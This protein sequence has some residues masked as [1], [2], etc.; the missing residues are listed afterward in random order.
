LFFIIGKRIGTRLHKLTNGLVALP[1]GVRNHRLNAF[2]LDEISGAMSAYNKAMEHLQIEE[3]RKT[4]IIQESI[5]AKTQAEAATAAKADFLANMSH[6]IRTPMN[7]I[8]G[9]T[10]LLLDT[11]LDSEQQEL[12]RMIRTSAESLLH[13]INDI[14]DFSKLEFAKMKLESLPVNLEQ[15]FQETVGIFA[16]QASGKGVELNHHVDPAMPR[17]IPGDSLRIKQILVNL[18]GNAMKFTQDGEILLMAQSIVR[19]TPAGEMPYMH[20]SVRD[21]GIGIP[22]DK[23]RQLFQAFTQADNSTTRKYGGTGLG[24]AISSKLCHLMGGEIGVRSEDGRGSNFFF[25][26]P[27]KALPDDP[28][29]MEEERNWQAAVRSLTAS[30]ISSHPTT[31]QII[32]QHCAQSGLRSEVSM[33]EPGSTAEQFLKSAPSLIVLDAQPDLAPLMMETVTLARSRGIAVVGATP[34]G[35]DPFKQAL[36]KA[37]GARCRFINKPVSR[38]DLMRAV[39]V[40]LSEIERNQPVPASIPVA[41]PAAIE[42]TAPPMVQS[43]QPI[44][45]SMETSTSDQAATETDPKEIPHLFADDFPAR[46]LVVEDQPMNQ[47]LARMMLGKLGYDHVDL[48]QNGSEAVDM[49]GRSPYDLVLMDLQMPVMGGEDAARLIRGNFGI[50]QQPIIVALTGHALSGVKESCKDAGMN[51]FLTKP[52]SIDDLRTVISGSVAH[53]VVMAS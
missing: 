32:Q 21:T 51:H 26:L 53:S 5:A 13:L 30:I 52:V 23:L 44:R 12:L 50:K 40:A 10:S 9:T 6:E 22:E 11:K 48:A 39:V 42:Q 7:G 8:L 24:L 1:T 38:R 14:L 47:K 16:Y 15:L 43:L 34:V 29:A 4:Q 33:I 35:Q 18:V 45:P 41:I 17:N 19:K 2:G 31:S 3:E 36:M 28:S 20:F 46:I 27:L 25:E 49:V 37:A